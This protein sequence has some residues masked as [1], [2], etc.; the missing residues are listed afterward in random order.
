M[1]KLVI[2]IAAYL[3]SITNIFASEHKGEINF[4]IGSS[5][6][7]DNNFSLPNQNTNEINLP[8]KK[9]LKSYRIKGILNIKNDKFLY[10]LYAPFATD[11]NLKSSKS[12]KFNNTNFNNN[13]NTKVDY[14][15]N[16]YRVGYFKELSFKNNL[17]YW[18]GG[19]LK[20]RDAKIK[21]SQNSLSDSYS[22]IGVVPLL[23]FGIKYF[24]NNDISLFSHI[25]ASGFS[26]GYAYDFNA[27]ARYR[28]NNKNY[29]GLGY[30]TFG[31]GVDNSKLMNFARFEILYANYNF[32]F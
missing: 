16:S 21:V 2:Y 31:G 29:T 26:K 23:G 8:D 12:F 25:D 20:V 18:V 7:L 27:E 14:K 28:I 9:Y 24:I 11:Y 13:Q 4:E 3:L 19:V 15:F 6:S 32:S 17:K 10:F 22:N 30:R 5:N 1:K